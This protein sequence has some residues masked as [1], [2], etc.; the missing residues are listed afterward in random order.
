MAIR[1]KILAFDTST[2]ACSVALLHSRDATNPVRMLHE[3]APRQQ[4]KRLIPMMETLLKESS[5]SVADLD[6]IAFSCGPGSFTGLRIASSVAQA[7]GFGAN[8]PVIPVSSLAAMAMAAHLE[9][10]WSSFLVA[11]DARMSEVY[12][13]AYQI[14][15]EG[16]VE[17]M[18]KEETIRPKNVTIVGDSTWCALGDGWAAYEKALVSRLGFKPRL[19]KASQ[20][21]TANAVALLAKPVYASGGA[22]PA[23]LALPTYLR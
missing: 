10:G 3:L 14:N 20:L 4:T 19:I 2:F 1:L 8:L 5:L 22:V 11:E 21:P 7:I 18:G 16:E 17:L 13:A 6:A 15:A 12:W 9:E 23:S